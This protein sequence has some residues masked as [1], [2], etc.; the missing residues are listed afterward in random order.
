MQT[1]T[2][3]KK[4]VTPSKIVCIGRNYVEHI[5][6]LANEPPD[7]MVVFLKPNSA[8]STELKS[9]HQEPLHYESELSFLYK[10]GKFSAVGFGLDLTKRSLQ[11]HLKKNG[12]PWE[13]AKAFDG[14]AVF[15]NFMEISEITPSL[16]LELKIDNK[17]VQTGN[18][19]SMIYKPEQILTELSTFIT[20]QNG[21]VVMTGTPEGVGVIRLNQLFTGTVRDRGET[22]VSGEWLA[23]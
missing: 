5:I 19:D 9:S 3:N 2:V 7:Q 16:T 22:I 15:S 4:S 6:E 11:S 14:S 13:R 8:I 18:I 23:K 12:L 10:N 17:T 1:I 20:L 21:D